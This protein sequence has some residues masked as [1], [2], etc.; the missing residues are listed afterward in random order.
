L[1]EDI[2][3][4]AFEAGGPI[5]SEGTILVTSEAIARETRSA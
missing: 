5:D 2:A 3:G 4:Q 1:I